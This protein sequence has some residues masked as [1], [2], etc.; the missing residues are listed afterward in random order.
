[1]IKK[2]FTKNFFSAIIIAGVDH[3]EKIKNNF[4]RVSA[5]KNNLSFAFARSGHTRMAKKKK[6]KK[7]K[8]KRA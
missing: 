1:L 2:L 7:T 8:K 3:S 4:F 6:A 5:L